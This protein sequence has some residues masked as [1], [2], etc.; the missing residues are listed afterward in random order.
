MYRTFGAEFR[1]ETINQLD[2]PSALGCNNFLVR[3]IQ[4]GESTV[5]QALRN[6]LLQFNGIRHSF[7]HLSY[8]VRFFR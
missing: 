6:L 5:I 4:F 1:S 8:R 3:T 2:I 7:T